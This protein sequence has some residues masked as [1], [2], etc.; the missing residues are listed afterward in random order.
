MGL[1]RHDTHCNMHHLL[2]MLYYLGTVLQH[3][4]SVVFGSDRGFANSRGNKDSAV[5]IM[6]NPSSFYFVEKKNQVPP[7]LDEDELERCLRCQRGKYDFGLGKIEHNNGKNWIFCEACDRVILMNKC[8]IYWKVEVSRSIITKG[9]Q[10][11]ARARR[12][13]YHAVVALESRQRSRSR[14]R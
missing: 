4:L 10:I 9:I 14:S 13:A 8:W 2:L 3:S 6:P 7:I 1:I 11:V 5:D 12:S